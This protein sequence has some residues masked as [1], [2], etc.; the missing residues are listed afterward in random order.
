MDVERRYRID[1][2]PEHVLWP[3]LVRHA[4]W[5]VDRY[6][7]RKHG[8]TAFMQ[9]NDCGYRGE[10]VVFAEVVLWRLQ[11][12]S[13]RRVGGMLTETGRRQKAD[14]AWRH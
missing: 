9:L 3:W 6:A 14:P 4:G 1:I 11:I 2:T 13:D 10:I 8:R 5:C 7:V 12:P